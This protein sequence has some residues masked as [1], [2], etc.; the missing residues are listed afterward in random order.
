MKHWARTKLAGLFILNK[1][2]FVPQSYEV[3]F[4]DHF[5]YLKISSLL[6]HNYSRNVFQVFLTV[7]TKINFETHSFVFYIVG[8]LVF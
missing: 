2:A 5:V 7:G 3:I 6:S 4:S 8:F 1:C